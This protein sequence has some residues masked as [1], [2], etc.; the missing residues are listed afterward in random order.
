MERFKFSAGATSGNNPPSFHV[1]DNMEDT[2]DFDSQFNIRNIKRSRKEFTGATINFDKNKAKEKNVN[3]HKKP[4]HMKGENVLINLKAQ[5]QPEISL[6]PVSLDNSPN[7]KV[8]NIQM[9]ESQNAL[10]DLPNNDDGNQVKSMTEMNR[11]Q[12]TNVSNKDMNITVDTILDSIPNEGIGDHE[13][14]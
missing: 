11:P 5:K 1:T 12:P 4:D 14:L 2:N 10:A 9:G 6:N 7:I 3:Q 13:M 8:T